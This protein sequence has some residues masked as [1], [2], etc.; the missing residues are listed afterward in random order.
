MRVNDDESEDEDNQ[1]Q[2]WLH[3][4]APLSPLLR[5]NHFGDGEM[6]DS[7]E[8]ENTGEFGRDDSASD[9]RRREDEV[10]QQ[11]EEEGCY[12]VFSIQLVN[13]S[14]RFVEIEM[15]SSSSSSSSYA[16]DSH[17]DM[18]RYIPWSSSS[19]G[20]GGGA[21]IDRR[22]AEEESNFRRAADDSGRC[23]D[24]CLVRNSNYT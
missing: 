17:S 14:I 13:T 7:G 22:S 6:G 16:R 1:Q 12:D 11:R 15:P 3:L 9:S 2:A 18:D 20:D 19:G 23:R 8:H 24:N 5:A 10:Q 21:W 4:K